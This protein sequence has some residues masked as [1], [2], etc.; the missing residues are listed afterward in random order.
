MSIYLRAKGYLLKIFLQRYFFGVRTDEVNFRLTNLKRQRKGETSFAWT[1]NSDLLHKL[2][3]FMTEENAASM[4]QAPTEQW[5]YHTD[6]HSRPHSILQ[7]SGSRQ[8]TVRSPPWGSSLEAKGPNTPKWVT[9]PQVPTAPLCK[10]RG[11]C[12]SESPRIQ[13]LLF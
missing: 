13:E 9:K 7:A 4:A 12:L 5:P 11:F 6:G 10:K 8:P 3:H 1:L 2:S